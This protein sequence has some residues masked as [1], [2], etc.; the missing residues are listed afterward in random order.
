M[1]CP[2][3]CAAVPNTSDLEM[4]SSLSTSSWTTDVAPGVGHTSPLS[5][6]SEN[7]EMAR[8]I[9]N[10]PS[11]QVGKLVTSEVPR[12]SYCKWPHH[13]Q[14]Y[15]RLFLQNWTVCSTQSSS[16]LQGERMFWIFTWGGYPPYRSSRLQRPIP[17]YQLSP[18][19]AGDSTSTRVSLVYTVRG[20]RE[21]LSDLTISMNIPPNP[22]SRI[23]QASISPKSTTLSFCS[24]E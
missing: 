18:K 11:C 4:F 3:L 17:S 16:L 10:S 21:S 5:H 8:G 20:S 22:Q 2:P 19:R 12:G 23:A 15:S 6:Q 7:K 1:E 24:H 14:G 13:P 9:L